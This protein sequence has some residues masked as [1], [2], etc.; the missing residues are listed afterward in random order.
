MI[1]KSNVLWFVPLV[2][3]ALY[4][5]G[6][7]GGGNS[8]G[9]SNPTVAV[10]SGNTSVA[11]VRYDDSRVRLSYPDTWV[12]RD[13]DGAVVQFAY[14]DVNETGGNDNCTL[15][16]G[17]E[18]GGSLIEAV[19]SLLEIALLPSPEPSVELVSVNGIAASRVKGFI[20]YLNFRIPS[21][22]Q[23]IYEDDYLYALVC[24]G[25]G[26]DTESQIIMSS[27]EIL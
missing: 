20:Q 21:Y 18:P 23:I 25:N 11:T 27:M 26:I 24:V 6:G 7:G 22:S 15:S 14:P 19:D 12:R 5:C 8:G 9:A 16:Y 2:A 13:A 1:H 10:E 4:G 3:T 17:Y